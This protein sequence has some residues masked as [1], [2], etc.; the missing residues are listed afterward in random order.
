MGNESSVSL[1]FSNY[2]PLEQ[3]QKTMSMARN[4]G[5]GYA[6]YNIDQNSIVRYFLFIAV[7]NRLQNI[8]GGEIKDDF[9]IEDAKFSYSKFGNAFYSILFSHLAKLVC[10]KS[11]DEVKNISDNDVLNDAMEELNK[12]GYS[13]ESLGCGFTKIVLG[14]AVGSVKAKLKI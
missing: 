3:A 1:K 8:S 11:V 2:I 14:S 13:A 12:Y 9:R 7:G 5:G 4:F 6:D 10:G